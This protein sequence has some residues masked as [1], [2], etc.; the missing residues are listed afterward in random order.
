[1]S[2]AAHGWRLTKGSVA[3][4][5][6]TSSFVNDKRARFCNFLFS[7]FYYFYFFA[8][9]HFCWNVL[10]SLNASAC[11]YCFFCAIF[12]TFLSRAFS[13]ITRWNL[14]LATMLQCR[15]FSRL[16]RSWWYLHVHAITRLL[17]ADVF[18]CDCHTVG[19]QF[20]YRCLCIYFY[21][22]CQAVCATCQIDIYL[23]S[24]IRRRC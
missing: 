23:S 21:C 12:S 4:F 8:A 17:W 10:I 6:P 1:M 9:K 20:C 19:A 3:C 15:V 16:F 14:L 22:W 7:P 13:A 11:C 2:S 5:T 18:I 24:V